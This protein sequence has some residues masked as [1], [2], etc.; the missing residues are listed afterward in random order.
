MQEADDYIEYYCPSGDLVAVT[1]ED[2]VNV[3]NLRW[4]TFEQFKS[5]A[6][7]VW[8]TQL[9]IDGNEWKNRRCTC[10]KYLKTYICK[11]NVGLAIRFRHVRAPPA[12]KDVPIGEKRKRGR[13]RKLQRLY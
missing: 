13:Q 6:F 2:V 11:H 8:V 4:N 12:A 1:N 10:P 3:T 5:R 7:K 9:P